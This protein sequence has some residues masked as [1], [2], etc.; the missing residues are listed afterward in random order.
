MDCDNS[1]P[2]IFYFAY[3]LTNVMMSMYVTVMYSWYTKILLVMGYMC[4][5][6]RKLCCRLID[7]Y[8]KENADNEI[9]SISL[10]ALY[11]PLYFFYYMDIVLE[12]SW[13]MTISMYLR[14][15][16]VEFVSPYC[17]LLEDEIM[18][19]NEIYLEKRNEMFNCMF[20]Q[21]KNTIL[22]NMVNEK[23]IFDS[24]LKI[25]Q[26]IRLVIWIQ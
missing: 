4:K 17:S 6:N 22:Q 25:R 11:L 13:N 1:I 20:L 23:K 3:F 26:S 14:L 21:I 5:R 18:R 16:K 10:C 7:I 19:I 9:L 24:P 8:R 12:F 2:E 15:R